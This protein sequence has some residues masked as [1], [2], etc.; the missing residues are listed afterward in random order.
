MVLN[1]TFHHA[2]A[3]LDFDADRQQ[4]TPKNPDHYEGDGPQLRVVSGNALMTV[5]TGIIPLPEP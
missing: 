2:N 1:R 4:K 3:S 5:L